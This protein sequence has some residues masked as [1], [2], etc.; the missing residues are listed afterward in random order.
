[1]KGVKPLVSAIITTH[2]RVN[3]LPRAV[4]SVLVQ[5]YPNIELIIV[6]DASTGKT[7][8]IIEKYKKQYHLKYIR[9]KKSLGAPAARNKGIEV[10]TGK[11]IAGLDDDDEW[12]KDRISELVAAYTEE[13]SCVTSDAKMFYPRGEAVWKKKKMIDLETL[14]LTNQVGNQVLVRRDYLKEI[15]AF[16]ESL[17]AAQDYDLWIRLCTTFGPIRNV[18]KPLQNVYM[19]H[20]RERITEHASF[21]GYLQFYKKHKKR[22]NKKQRK[23][24][25]YKIRRAQEKPEGIR[26]FLNCVPRQRYFKETKRMLAERLWKQ[27]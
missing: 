13:Y 23:Y 7:Q 27:R 3:L 6:D 11:F 5:T 15:G 20:E 25:L 22:F 18:R 8:K 21:E 9:N 24:Q 2:N 12:H 4:D 17:S 26:E 10:A 16:D 1:M 14:L 19:N